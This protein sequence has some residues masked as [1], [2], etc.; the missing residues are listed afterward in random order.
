MKPYLAMLRASIM[1]S[2]AYRSGY[3]FTFLNNLIYMGIAFYLWR[4]I[5]QGRAELRG[6]S[7]NQTF[8]Y[9]ALASSVFVL[10]KTWNDWIMADEIKTGSIIMTLI[11]PI[12]LQWFVLARSAGFALLNLV[13]ITV[14]TILFLLLIFRVQ[15]EWGIGLLFF[16]IG[17][18]MAFLLN[19][20]IDYIIGL[21]CFYT[22]SIW[23]ISSTKEILIL[24]LSGS[25][26][27]LPFFPE[28]VQ[29]FLS[30]LPF[31]A[32]YHLPLSML[33]DPGQPLQHYGRVLSIQ[34]FWVCL[35]MLLARLYYKQAVK[36][37]RVSGG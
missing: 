2:L 15:I 3:I 20:T 32:M 24:F 31:Q 29:K 25:L 37:L 19:T 5:F 22:E 11:K 35:L 6:M 28:R 27:P 17:V 16:P 9:V 1:G 18:I 4:S 21:T 30:V 23:G 8:L 10:F 13:T 7:F 36:V 34:L 33:V 26:I 12:N 14:P